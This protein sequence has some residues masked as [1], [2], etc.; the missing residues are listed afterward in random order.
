M[1]SGIPLERKSPRRERPWPEPGGLGHLPAPRGSARSA[2]TP[3][4][5]LL[6]RRQRTP[7]N[8]NR[9][10][11]YRA[12]CTNSTYIFIGN[13]S[14]KEAQGAGTPPQPQGPAGRGGEEESAFTQSLLLPPVGLGA[15]SGA[16]GMLRVPGQGGGNTQ[17]DPDLSRPRA[18]GSSVGA[19]LDCLY[20]GAEVWGAPAQGQSPGRVGTW[21]IWCLDS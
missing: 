11:I 20:C 13:Q 14:D 9:S 6:T 5:G 4:A 2:L 15:C 8:R 18:S 12:R 19:G 17:L 21:R 3:G 7:N 16:A 10:V 1:G